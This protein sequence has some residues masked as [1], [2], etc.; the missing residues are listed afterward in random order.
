MFGGF[1]QN[2]QQSSGFGAGSGFGGTSTGGGRCLRSVA[3]PSSFF[4]IIPCSLGT[5]RCKMIGT[6]WC[7]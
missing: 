3:T 1:G 7:S 6:C 5:L 4:R 2:N